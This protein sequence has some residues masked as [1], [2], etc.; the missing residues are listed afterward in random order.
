[1]KYYAENYGIT[2][3]TEIAEKLNKL[4]AEMSASDEQKELIFLPGFY[5]IDADN[6]P[7]EELYITNTI[8]EKEY[9]EGELPHI[10]RVA[11]DLKNINNLKISGE[12]AVFVIKGRVTNAIVVNCSNIVFEGIEIKAENPDLHEITV[13]K[14]TLTHVDFSLDSESRYIKKNGKFY[15]TGKDYE[16]PFFF[17]LSKW[18]YF[19]HISGENPD[20]IVRCRQPLTGAYS[21]KELS[22]HHFRA[23]YINTRSFKVGDTYCL[24]DVRRTNVGFFIEKSKDVV[25]KS[26]KQR[27]NVSLAVV[28]QNSENITIDSVEF[29]P[30]DNQAK[31]FVSFADFIQ[32][33]MCKGKISIT[34]SKFIGAGDDV[35]NVH[36]TH[37]KIKSIN[38]NNIKCEFKHPQ[39][40]GY[41]AFNEGDEIEFVNSSTLLP[42]GKAK[43]INACLDDN[44]TVSLDVDNTSGAKVGQ[45][46]ENITLCPDLY[47]AR[48]YMA[49]IVTRGLLIT[50]RGKVVVEDNEFQNLIMPSILFSDDAKSWYESGRCTD[51]TIRNNHFNDCDACYIQILPENRPLKNPVHG[52]FVIEGN[53]FEHAKG[54]DA[55]NSEELIFRNNIIKEKCDSFVKCTNVVKTDIIY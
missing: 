15:F 7:T 4:L 25:L 19:G 24:Y 55:R 43:V 35:L 28:A 8:G 37:F 14:V 10:Q 3:G 23:R 9:K 42:E 16:V 53:T 6:C 33:C 41:L 54:I 49:R 30:A 31:K 29:C 11:F 48:N 52:R 26:V 17:N 51:V 40:Y 1:M 44:Y 36:G 47:F 18:G 46:I 38:G 2:P 12:G 20:R 50:T 22:P 27:F 13:E 32:I 34:D 39:S 21:L 5:Y 45:V